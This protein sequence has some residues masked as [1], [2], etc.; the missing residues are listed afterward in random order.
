MSDAVIT[1]PTA[2]LSALRSAR[3]PGLLQAVLTKELRGRMRGW[4]A[5]TV[6]TVYLLLLSGFTMLIYLAATAGRSVGATNDPAIGKF[7][8]FGVTGL[9]LGLVAFLAPAFSAGIISSEREKQTYDLLMTTPLPSWVIVIGKLLAALAYLL[10]LVLTGLPLVSL[11]YLLGGVAPDE[12]L[13]AMVLLLVTTLTYGAIGLWFS[14]R[15]RSTIAATAMTYAVVVLPL[16]LIPMAIGLSLAILTS[17]YRN[18]PPVWLIYVYNVLVSLNPLLAGGL[19][20]AALADGKGLGLFE[21]D[22]DRTKVVVISPWL[23]LTGIYLTT[24]V[25]LIAASIRRLRA[26][27]RA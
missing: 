17:V 12:V 21:M 20:A 14:A 11:G 6:L 16:A 4:R 10:L 18:E 22:F 5:L 27:A 26:S 9:Q 1:P 3:W 15:L 25:V 24:S 19:T 13:V 8:F 7:V 23:L 2:P